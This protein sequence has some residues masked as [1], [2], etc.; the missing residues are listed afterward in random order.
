MPKRL[1]EACSAALGRIVNIARSRHVANTAGQFAAASR[2][3]RLH[4]SARAEAR[5]GVTVNAIAPG[6][7]ARLSPRPVDVPPRSAHAPVNLR[8]SE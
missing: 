5:V 7:I 4:Q 1:C 8:Q 2:D 6:Y 3:A